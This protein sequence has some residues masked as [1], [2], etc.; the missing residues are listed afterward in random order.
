MNKI[1]LFLAL[2]L[3]LLVA[4]PAAAQG[5]IYLPIIAKG[6]ST[7]M[8]INPI[9][10]ISDGSTTIDL[11]GPG[12]GW[13]LA[14]PGWRPQIS[15]F[16]GGGSMVDS[17]LADGQTLVHSQYSNVTESIPLSVTGI[18][19]DA[20]MSTISELLKLGRQT[21]DYYTKSYEY[22]D[23]WLEARPA[24]AALTGYTRLIKLSIPE[25]S[26]V[27]GQPFFSA[28]NQ[29]VMEDI[30]LIVERQPFW[31][32]VP[33]GEMIG[34]L[35][36]LLDNGDFELWNGGVNN[37]APDSWTDTQSFW[38]TGEISRD[39]RPRF[40]EYATKINVRGSTAANASK[41]VT[42]I[43][44][45]V[46]SG[47]EY[48]I[49]AWVRSEGVSNG[50]AR[51]LVNYS[52]QLELYRSSTAHG[53]TLYTGKIT[54]GLNDTVSIKCEILTTAANTVGAFYVDSIMVLP[55][56][57]EEE[58]QN[59]LLPY[60]SNSHIVNHSDQPGSAVV[61]SGDI[62]WLDCWNV[63]GDVD[64]LVKLE[65]M[66]VTVPADNNNP[67]ENIAR[68]RVGLRRT[69]DVT[70]FDNYHDPIGAIDA[71]C[72]GGDKINVTGLNTS[73]KDVTKKEI[74]DVAV[75]AHNQGRFRVFAR[76]YDNKASGGSTLNT[77]LYTNIGSANINTV[78]YD[79]VTSNIVSG[80][81][82]IDLTP[83]KAVNFDLSKENF[84]GQLT[85]SLQMR[86]SAGSDNAA[87]D[88]LEIMP[89]SGGFVETELDPPL[90]YKYTLAADFSSNRPGMLVTGMR[91]GFKL[92]Q[93]FNLEYQVR[94]F[95]IFNNKLYFSTA[96]GKIYTY[97]NG[98]ITL[99]YGGAA[100]GASTF[101]ETYNGYLYAG[102]SSNLWRT[103]GEN[104]PGVV[105][106]TSPGLAT[107][108]TMR[109]YAGKL[110]LGDNNAVLSGW[111]GSAF[112][113]AATGE[114]VIFDIEPY[115]NELYVATGGAAAKVWKFNLVTSVMSLS[116][117]FTGTAADCLKSYDG[118]LYTGT[119]NNAVHVFDGL[120]W[121]PTNTPA[122]F[123]T[124]VGDLEV[125]NGKLY[126]VGGAASS[127]VWEFDGTTWSLIYD[128]TARRF[129]SLTNFQGNLVIGNFEAPGNDAV[130]FTVVF[131]S[132]YHYVAQF[133]GSKLSPPNRS[134]DSEA[135]HRYFF[136]YD[137]PNYVNVTTD[138]I[139]V[140]I[141]FTPRF[142]SLPS[143]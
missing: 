129:W 117:T 85:Y 4:L 140:G 93:T 8:S 19:Q 49:V 86:R 81:N 68:I 26:D 24:Q 40:G 106:T 139:L 57:W 123:L 137:R 126:A 122:G 104:F 9:L 128:T 134:R 71:T 83:T 107:I 118:K 58:A 72:S 141:G 136:M 62:N 2:L 52:S 23:V 143:K 3:M 64:P 114:T 22:N 127:P 88:Y 108:T 91:T 95:A 89:T 119:N 53:W 30:T 13:Q 124:T 115:G 105:E 34:P 17:G 125:V 21:S 133:Q 87:F 7:E 110:W 111:D 5:P 35:Y 50:V 20:A 55:G 45:D 14:D 46:V 103:D 63:P 135:R 131:L 6:S 78:Y 33:P 101:L 31:Q 70:R 113:S 38:I 32:A 120:S 98:Q 112:T 99:K 25:L 51:I 65:M 36:N 80:W 12:S 28:Y 142:L 11:L 96:A 79:E 77:R 44:D 47:T 74:K 42:Q 10:R 18:D 41:G 56:D 132:T 100:Y 67:V 97:Y 94:S 102:A 29:P 84:P 66:N 92:L 73:W 60:L 130:L 61:S 48:T 90:Y 121:T 116:S 82:V 75:T 138:K 76:L 16:K 54:T 1:L 27:Y 109:T 43:L 39:D 15:Q 37:V 69:Q 59:N